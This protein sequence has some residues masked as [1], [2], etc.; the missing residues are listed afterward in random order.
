MK[1]VSKFL[2]LILRHKPEAGKLR[3]DGEGWAD[4]DAV[5]AA[6]QSRFGEFDRDALEELVRT[7]DKQRYRFDETGTRIRANQGH[8]LPVELGLEPRAPPHRLYHGT[9]ERF[10]PSIME[11]G[12]LKGRRQHVHLSGDVET[13]L[14]VGGRRGRPALLEVLSGDMSGHLFFRSA[15]GVWLT[16]H[17]P[18]AYL[19]ALT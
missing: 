9:S 1:Q 13:A 6:V 5:L 3:L 19:R 12:L 11:Q 7:N 18:P 10:L 16:D 8:S 4:V 14:K 15:N 17:V 2:A